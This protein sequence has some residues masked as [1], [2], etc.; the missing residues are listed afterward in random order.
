MIAF[1]FVVEAI[2]ECAISVA[3]GRPSLPFL[4]PWIVWE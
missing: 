2:I 1:G 3:F 4:F